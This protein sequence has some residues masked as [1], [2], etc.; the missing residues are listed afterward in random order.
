[1]QSSFLVDSRKYTIWKSFYSLS[2]LEHSHFTRVMLLRGDL[3]FRQSLTRI[4]LR[5]MLH[6][7][8]SYPSFDSAIMILSFFF[9]INNH[10]FLS[11]P[12]SPSSVGLPLTEVH[13]YLQNP[14]KPIWA[15]YCNWAILIVSSSDSNLAGIH[16][17]PFYWA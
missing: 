16:H 11:I 4:C 1:M 3:R 14:I 12:I 7:H 10:D 9:W 2:D 15:V 17:Q 13:S 6:A 8:A 5:V